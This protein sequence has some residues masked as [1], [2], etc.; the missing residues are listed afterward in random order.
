MR[1]VAQRAGVSTATVSHVLNGTRFVRPET[2]ER[3][4]A[5]IAELQYEMNG[6]AQSLRVR[7]TWTL[8][9]IIP[10]LANPFFPE[11]AT[12]IQQE[13]ARAGYDV[14]IYSIDVPHGSS[15]DLLE[16]YLRAIRRKRYDA[17][18][19]AETLPVSPMSRQHLIDT[20]TPLVL[21]GGTPHPQ[22]DRVYIDD[23]VASRDVITYLAGKGH[24]RIAHI[25]GAPDMAS[26]RD[27]LRGYRDGL[28]A[29][30][31]SPS[32]DLEVPGTFLRE[33]G[34]TAMQQLL[35][36]SPRPTA[37]FAAN[38]LTALGALLA[39]VDAQVRV[40]DDIAIVGFD[41]ISLAANVR[42]ALTTVY[43]GQQEIGREAVR[44][45]VRAHRQ[46]IAEGGPEQKETVT[47]PHR[48]V[49]RDSA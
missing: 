34:Y 43:H 48:L 33:G 41:D 37:V 8:A 38:D 11:M 22:A 47:V 15:A 21:I 16:H 3:V 46:H 12:V 18:I 39:C 27:R 49:V 26:S 2:G 20:G 32:P 42:P 9:L 5:A 40:P 1:D 24:R 28:A 14:V 35:A 45:A 31:V 23:Y 6:T 19:Y 13:A 29:A 17:V 25:T 7:T 30:G 44:L 10:D 36:R 4:R